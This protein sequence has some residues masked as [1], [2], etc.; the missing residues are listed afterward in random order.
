MTE[1]IHSN[2]GSFT[3]HCT[4]LLANGLGAKMSYSSDADPPGGAAAGVLC[5][6]VV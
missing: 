4:R 1:S 5:P 6:L 2:P 3:K